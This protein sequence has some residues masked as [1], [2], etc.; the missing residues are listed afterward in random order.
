M[1]FLVS[2]NQGG[3]YDLALANGGDLQVQDITTV[4]PAG[5]PGALL[6]AQ[7]Y[8]DPI[9]GV[10]T[11]A[12]TI[13]APVKTVMGGIVPKWGT[14]EPVFP[15]SVPLVQ[16]NFLNDETLG[17]EV[18]VLR[19]TMT[20]I[21][22]IFAIVGQFTQIGTGSLG[23]T[24][25]KNRAAGQRLTTL[26]NVATGVPPVAGQFVRNTTAGKLSRAPLFS[27][28][29]GVMC[30]PFVPAPAAAPN[31]PLAPVEV[32][33]WAAGDTV[34]YE[35][36]TKINL[37]EI[38]ATFTGNFNA[39]GSAQAILWILAF[40]CLDL[41]GAVGNSNCIFQCFGGQGD[42]RNCI[43]DPAIISNTI[44]GLS[45]SGLSY[46]G[47]YLASTFGNAFAGATF[48]RGGGNAGSA[49]CAGQIAFNDDTIIGSEID[50]S[51]SGDAINL[52]N[53]YVTASLKP[54]AGGVNGSQV[55][56]VNDDTGSAALYGPA[57][58]QMRAGSSMS[59]APGGLGPATF[60]ACLL[61]SGAITIDSSATASQYVAGVWTAGI[62]ITP[63]NLDLHG[64]LLNPVTGTRICAFT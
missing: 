60:V 49:Q 9:N 27:G 31:A 56:F 41:T 26:L 57:T 59:H 43:V 20:A 48:I 22:A 17:Q 8:V 5:T 13:T 58:V 38:T 35:R 36:P 28:G 61:N 51:G 40:E 54:G 63:A 16:I 44:G 24:T 45:A 39:A 3:N 47:S 1:G 42:V 29:I 52:G 62:A 19:P 37:G 23:V 25:P 55:T 50:A 2:S 46:T 33:T 10:E 11:N 34:V 53:V 7:W 15:P 14:N 32:D 4:P 21:A 30:Q 6:Q 12:G 18:I 64:G